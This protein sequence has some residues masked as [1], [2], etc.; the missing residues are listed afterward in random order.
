MSDI[1]SIRNMRAAG[2]TP[3]PSRHTASGEGVIL[4]PGQ[5][6]EVKRESLRL[7]L[8]EGIVELDEDGKPVNVVG[9]KA[10]RQEQA[11]LASRAAK[12]VNAHK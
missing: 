3:I 8:G 9:Q 7:L 12:S 2:V 5:T 1:V 11:R 10:L 4:G 6:V